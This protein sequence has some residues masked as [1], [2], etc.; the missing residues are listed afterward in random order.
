M[1]PRSLSELASHLE[2]SAVGSLRTER[3]L[4]ELNELLS[5]RYFADQ[6]VMS[7]SFFQ[8]S[9]VPGPMLVASPMPPQR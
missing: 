4:A 3:G 7:C 1:L 2:A 6:S 5:S 9:T 8:L